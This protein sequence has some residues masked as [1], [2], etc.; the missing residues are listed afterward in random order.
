MPQ[1]TVTNVDSNS[2]TVAVADVSEW[3]AV[4]RSAVA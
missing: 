3:D 4:A 2:S 1:T